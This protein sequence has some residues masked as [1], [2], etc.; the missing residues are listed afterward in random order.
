MAVAAR[1]I[2]ARPG[3]VAEKKV[4]KKSK[5]KE[6]TT[7]SIAEAVYEDLEREY[8]RDC[9]KEIVSCFVKQLRVA[10]SDSE[11]TTI[12]RLGVFLTELRPERIA[13]NPRTGEPVTVPPKVRV[14]FKL[15]KTALVIT[16]DE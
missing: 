4:T 3:K 12:N 14:R 1:P 16:E 11:K 8:S 6:S 2:I 5:P 15:S 9:V 7:Q 13:R 10:L